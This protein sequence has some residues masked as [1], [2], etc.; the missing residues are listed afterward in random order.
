MSDLR[1]MAERF[2]E[3][4]VEPGRSGRNWLRNL[5]AALWNEKENFSG[6]HPFGN[7][8]WD[9]DAYIAIV[10]HG[11]APG[12]LDDLGYLKGGDTR[13]YDRIVLSAIRLVFTGEIS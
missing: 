13:L 2:L 6:K 4:E 10:K 9:H 7:S 12:E 1:A 8:G 11:I 3:C 5:L